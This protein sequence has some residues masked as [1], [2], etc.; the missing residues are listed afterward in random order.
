VRVGLGIVAGG[1]L[2]ALAVAVLAPASLVDPLLAA[3]TGGRV[4][5]VDAGGFW[6]RGHGTLA[7]ANG[8]ARMPIAWRI[9]W[10]P[11]VARTLDVEF[12]PDEPTMPR[13]HVRVS[14]DTL[15]ARN[16]HLTV[17][18]ALLPAFAPALEAVAPAGDIDVSTASFAWRS[19]QATGKVDGTWR[20]ARLAILG[21]PVALGRIVTTASGTGDGAQG[22]FDNS[23]GEIA[24]HGT[25][26]AAGKRLETATTLTPTS[27][28]SPALH[29]LLPMLGHVDP[30]GGVHLTWQG[31]R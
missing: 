1:V 27:S 12:V 21:I 25:W 8:E 28:T 16:L 15:D 4:R 9:A 24:I 10:L 19:Q 6:W 13:G 5:L 23:A 3:R 31:Q 22:A 29:A 11:L 30:Q 18:A 2:L 14:R 17:P 26:R 20:N 7:A